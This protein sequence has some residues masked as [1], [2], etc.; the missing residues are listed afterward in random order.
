MVNILFLRSNRIAFEKA[1]LFCQIHEK[2]AIA[3]LQNKLYANRQINFS[4]FQFML[5]ARTLFTMGTT[6]S[7]C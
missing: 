7:V 3:C 5:Q 2:I 4:L 1:I 6:T